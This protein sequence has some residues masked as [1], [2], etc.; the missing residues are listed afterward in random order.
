VALY[1][2]NT[3]RNYNAIFMTLLPEGPAWKPCIVQWLSPSSTFLLF[4]TP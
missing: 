4:L 2:I 1:Q 3:S